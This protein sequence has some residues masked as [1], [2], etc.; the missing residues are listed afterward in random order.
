MRN[1]FDTTVD[2]W[3]D[4]AGQLHAYLLP[5]EEFLSWVEPGLEALSAFD[6]LA[7]QP[8]QALHATVQR[9]PYL[10]SSP[11]DVE[12]F[13]AAVAERRPGAVELSFARPTS[14]DL[15]V[16]SL[17][18][19]TG[20]EELTEAVRSAAAEVGGDPA[21]H[22]NPPFGPHITLAYG[23]GD[24]DSEEILAALA[25]IPEPPAQRFTELAWCAVHQV[26]GTYTFEVLTTT[27]LGA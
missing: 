14:D 26:E 25:E 8:P 11:C 6:C 7:P 15:A 12:A 22:Y 24:G 1:F 21:I 9:F 3:T 10:L 23:V 18:R 13:A 5:D 20:W 4:P 17:G 16:I 19:G 27:P 2:D